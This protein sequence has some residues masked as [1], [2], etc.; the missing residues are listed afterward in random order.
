[1]MRILLLGRSK[2][3]SLKIPKK[4]MNDD[5]HSNKKTLTTEKRVAGYVI[6]IVLTK[7]SLS[8]RYAY[9]TLCLFLWALL[10]SNDASFTSSGAQVLDGMPGR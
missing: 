3:P 9:L 1:M 7:Y 8:D 4:E 6:T 2:V 5:T 10:C